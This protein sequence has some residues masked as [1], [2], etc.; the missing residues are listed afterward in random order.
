MISALYA[1]R[2][3]GVIL[4]DHAAAAGFDVSSGDW[5]VE[6]ATIPIMESRCLELNVIIVKSLPLN[7]IAMLCTEEK[8]YCH[9]VANS[10]LSHGLVCV[11]L[12]LPA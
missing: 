9:A 2:A 1:I 8:P 10:I 5:W 12:W 3:G 4:L 6:Q 7:S 11:Y